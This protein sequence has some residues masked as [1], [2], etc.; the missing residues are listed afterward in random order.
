MKVTLHSIAAATAAAVVLSATAPAGAQVAQWSQSH[1]Y[2]DLVM[3]QKLV[4]GSHR[5]DYYQQQA[6]YQI[7][8]AKRQLELAAQQNGNVLD[9][10]PVQP[11]P[12]RRL[13]QAN[14][15]LHRASYDLDR[16][17]AIPQL[18]SMV[19]SAIAHI[20]LAI[21]DVKRDADQRYP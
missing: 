19:H 20:F 11:G 12:G 2:S 13:Q 5:H 10:A 9:S 3:A 6:L 21:D 8:L 15:L 17:Q 14:D 18:H 1:A 16:L 7:G 4:A